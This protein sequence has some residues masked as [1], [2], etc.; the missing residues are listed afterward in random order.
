MKALY[1]I[2]RKGI[3]HKLYTMIFHVHETLVQRNLPTTTDQM[4]EEQISI[5]VGKWMYFKGLE[6]V[7]ISRTNLRFCMWEWL[8]VHY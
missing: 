8:I 3:R 6:N 2:L 1:N 5:Y 4:N 7:P